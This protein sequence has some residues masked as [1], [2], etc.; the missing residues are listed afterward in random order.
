MGATTEI[1]G[2]QFERFVQ[3]AFRVQ[4]GGTVV[5]IDP[6]RAD[7]L[8]DREK[9]DLVLITHPHPDHMDPEALRAVLKEDTVV[10]TNPQTE[11]E[12]RAAAPRVVKLQE[13]QRTTE[14]GVE[15]RA[16]PGY[17]HVHPRGFNTGFVFRLGGKTVYHAGDTSLVPEMAELRD[18]DVA[19]LPIGGTYT[20]G[21]EEAANAVGVIQPRWVIPMHYGYATGGD[22]ERFRRRVGSAAGVVVL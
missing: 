7:L 8:R 21:E 22:P 11:R 5:Y 16:V 17:N 20:M 10:I 18:I 19:L 3:S 14:K 1:E 12:A 4:A 15:V 2:I 13:G 6:H 9:A